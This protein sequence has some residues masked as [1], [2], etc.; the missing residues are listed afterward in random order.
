MS[1]FEQGTGAEEEARTPLGSS[2]AERDWMLR[3]L[4]EPAS[5][6]PRWRAFTPWV[7]VLL[8]LLSSTML[9]WSHRV[10]DRQAEQDLAIEGALADLEVAVVSSHLWLE[11]FL[12]DDPDVD[13]QRDVFRN[14]E[15]ALGLV[16][17]IQRGG[18]S[19][20]GPWL[21]PMRDP[22]LKQRL[23]K[24][25]AELE[26]FRDLSVERYGE[27][28]VAGVGSGHDQR[29]DATFRRVMAGSKVLRHRLGD[30]LLEARATARFHR[31]II[32][33]AWML[34]VAA[35]V[36]GLWHRERQR[37]RVEKTLRASQRWLAT[38][39]A[40]LG[41]GVVTTTTEGRVLYLNPVAER[42]TG[43]TAEEAL[44][45][46]IGEV[47]RVCRAE[48]G[49]PLPNP[50]AEVLEGGGDDMSPDDE[51]TELLPREGKPRGVEAVASPIRDDQYELLGAVLVVRD[52]SRRRR[53]EAELE[54]R[55]IEL[56]QA[57]KMEAVGR[58]AGGIAH[59]VN[60]YLGAIRGTCEVAMLKAEAGEAL[61]R[62]MRSAIA[63]ADKVSGL[64]RQLLAFSRRQPVSA[65]VVDLN[66]IVRELEPMMTRL[67]G[68]DIQ[69]ALRLDP[70]PRTLEIDPGQLEQVL[71]NLLVNA[72]E[73]MG[74]GG[75]IVLE[76][77]ALGPGDPRR[78]RH[79]EPPVGHAVALVVRDAGCGI[80][81]ETL[82]KIF[83]P[84]YTTKGASGSSGLGLATVYGIVQQNGGSIL[85][86]SLV[87]E[88]TSFEL[89]FPASDRGEE[90]TENIP[91]LRPRRHA[92]G[93]EVLLVED[94]TAMGETAEAFFGLLGHRVIRATSGEEALELAASRRRPD[95]LVTDVVMPGIDGRTLRDE[96]HRRWP[97]LPCLFVSGYTDSA[98]LRRGV[99]EG[100]VHLLPKPFSLA[101]LDR[102]IEAVLQSVASSH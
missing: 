89:L 24:L 97:D 10:S 67:I 31:A 85:C 9:W 68:D 43:W 74:Q 52:V 79:A 66:R 91:E 11:E 27:R 86:H 45:R 57:Q 76:T 6:D 15:Q 50:V 33:A 4:F 65:R 26:E 58:L 99:D 37:L 87:G 29:Y 72:G 92:G 51:A 8:G 78:R 47:V 38:T 95:L 53:M 25:Q 19:D 71:V 77:F 82:E 75:R 18:A 73:A 13:I 35:A 81:P 56:R 84:F 80:P 88:G 102:A 21:E 101:E 96:L 61:E 14:Q 12:T 16:R 46:P 69:L 30:R 70:R 1:R 60:N 63:T 59:D 90:V 32:L 40:S 44:E 28:E 100:E 83:E 48:D 3:R 62:R 5:V 17:W 93:L 54:Q 20:E 23:E 98:L 94:N 7:V 39:L 41:D 42:L 34:A 49:R 2:D 22:D 64:I 36:A 55:Q